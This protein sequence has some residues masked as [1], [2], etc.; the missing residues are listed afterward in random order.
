MGELDGSQ[1]LKV[2][3]FRPFTWAKMIMI[4][5]RPWLLA[6]KPTG[7]FDTRPVPYKSQLYHSIGKLRATLQQLLFYLTITISSKFNLRDRDRLLKK[8]SRCR[9]AHNVPI[10]SSNCCDDDV[11]YLLLLAQRL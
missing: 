10:E 4:I 8:K 2:P 7:P 1:L 5:H 11:I 6:C 3:P 9:V